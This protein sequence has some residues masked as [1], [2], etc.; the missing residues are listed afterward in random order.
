L[1]GDYKDFATMEDF[2]ASLKETPDQTEAE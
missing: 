2:I 1:A